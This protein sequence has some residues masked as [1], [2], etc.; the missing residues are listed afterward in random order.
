VR[1]NPVSSG[2]SKDHELARQAGAEKPTFWLD[3]SLSITPYFSMPER[4]SVARVIGDG[5]TQAVTVIAGC[6][7]D[8][9]FAWSGA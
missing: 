9:E 4:R 3:D 5:L 1:I 2:T 8:A 7:R 6:G